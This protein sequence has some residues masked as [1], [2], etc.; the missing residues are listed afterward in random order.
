MLREV[1][2]DRP[3]VIATQGDWEYAVKKRPEAEVAHLWGVWIRHKKGREWEYLGHPYTGAHPTYDHAVRRFSAVEA[4]RGGM[5]NAGPVTLH[6][7]VAQ[8]AFDDYTVTERAHQAALDAQR[9]AEDQVA[10]ALHER[11]WGEKAAAK[12]ATFKAGPITIPLKDVDPL[13][14]R[15]PQYKGLAVHRGIG[16]S[17]LGAPGPH[18]DYYTVTH[19][20]SGCS[21]GLRFSSQGDAKIAAYRLAEH[22]D[23]SRSAKDLSKDCGL[24]AAIKAMLGDPQDSPRIHDP[25]AAFPDSRM[26]DRRP[27]V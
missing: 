9:A 12:A 3:E 15:A 16:P 8:A 24:K 25:H 10:Q 5:S 14:I 21:L 1:E 11:I 19:V 6:D 23:W 22:G 2:I 13:T 27:P 4:A 18:Q 20:E 7:P 17:Q 26:V